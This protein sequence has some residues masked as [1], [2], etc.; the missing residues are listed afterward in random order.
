MHF[1]SRY[2]NDIEWEDDDVD[3]DNISPYIDLKTPDRSLNN[4]RYPD[5]IVIKMSLIRI[6]FD[7]PLEQPVIYEYVADTIEGFTR[8]HLAKCV[9]Q[10]YKRIYKEED[11]FVTKQKHE[12]KYGYA[13][14]WMLVALRLNLID[15]FPLGQKTFGFFFKKN[16]TAEAR[17]SSYD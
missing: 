14:L 17:D 13:Y 11:D 10:G 9:V 2:D 7:Y 15:M 3:D 4:Q 5:E 12:A 1:S 16:L 6:Q 8:R